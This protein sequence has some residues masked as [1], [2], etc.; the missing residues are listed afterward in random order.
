LDSIPAGP[1]RDQVEWILGLLNDPDADVTEDEV[2]GH[3]NED[4]LAEV[5][6]TQVVQ[7]VESLRSE[8][9]G[10]EVTGVEVAP[11]GQQAQVDVLGN[12]GLALR[13]YVVVEPGS[14]LISGLL[15]QPGEAQAQDGDATAVAAS[16]VAS[17][18]AAATPPPSTD[19]IL[20]D[21]QAA[22]DE[23]MS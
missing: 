20:A 22:V 17:P 3:F 21:Y 18:V 14:G 15:F 8:L 23:L 11:D 1:L 12:T 9:R 6:A 4:F 2:A 5:P 7:I 10:V 16:P 13:I 19:E